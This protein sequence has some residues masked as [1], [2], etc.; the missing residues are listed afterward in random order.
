ML[1]YDPITRITAEDAL[2]HPYFEED[3]I[4][5]MDSFDGQPFQYPSRSVKHDDND[6]KAPPAAANASTATQGQAGASQGGVGAG[7]KHAHSGKDEGR[8]N[9]RRG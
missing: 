4:P 3:P 9:K 6:M 1:E 8:N 5:S 2:K 7:R